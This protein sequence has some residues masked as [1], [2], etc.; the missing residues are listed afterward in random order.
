VWSRPLPRIGYLGA[1]D[2]AGASIRTLHWR[3]H[4]GCGRVRPE[5]GVRGVDCRGFTNVDAEARLRVLHLPG[6]DDDLGRGVVWRLEVKHRS[7]MAT[8]IPRTS[9]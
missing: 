5:S 4:L 9:T 7:S 2:R 1:P 3:C 6:A 8:R